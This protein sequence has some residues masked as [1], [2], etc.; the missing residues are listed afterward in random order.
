MYEFIP[1]SLYI[2]E[3]L[4]KTSIYEGN[5]AQLSPKPHW[6]IPIFKRNVFQ[7]ITSPSLVHQHMKKNQQ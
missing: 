3:K 2:S 6:Q 4:G 5:D 1:F 7:I